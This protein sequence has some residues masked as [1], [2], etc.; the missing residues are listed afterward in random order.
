MTKLRTVKNIR[1]VAHQLTLNRQISDADRLMILKMLQEGEKQGTSQSDFLNTAS[2]RLQVRILN[3][4]IRK[5]KNS[6][7]PEDKKI[8]ALRKILDS[9]QK[10]IDCVPAKVLT[11]LDQLEITI[12]K[13]EISSITS[14]EMFDR[15]ER[16]EFLVS[17]QEQYDATSQSWA[18]IENE[19]TKLDQQLRIVS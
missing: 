6:S 9:Y 17:A 11:I 18:L 14:N 16:V 19:I 5:I 10:N 3:L 2:E 15:D 13:L 1:S 7:S 8:D 4:K 12:A